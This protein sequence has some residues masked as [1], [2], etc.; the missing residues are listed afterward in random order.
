MN[1]NLLLSILD[2]ERRDIRLFFTMK[3]GIKYYTYSPGIGDNIHDEL[4]KLI[5]EYI[6]K[7]KDFEQVD[8]SPVGYK[9]GTIETC[10]CDYVASYEDVVSTFK[11][12]EVERDPISK[13][14]INK[15]NFYCIKINLDL[16][17]DKKELLLFRR[18]TKF[19]KLSTS[20]IFGS[21]SNNRFEKID[22]DLLGLDGDLDIAVYDGKMIVFNHIA[23]ERIFSLKKQYLESA[24]EAIDIIRK[25]G[26]ISNF[27]QFE[28]D[29]LNDNRITRIL[30]RM[31][32]EEDDLE[33]CFENFPNVI[34]VIDIFEL[35]IDIDNSGEED[36]IVYDNK[37]QLMDVIRLVRDS[38]YKSIIRELPGIDDAI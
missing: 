16:E 20:G 2:R 13:E 1:I 31:L 14:D 6:V 8:F 3:R 26:R 10:D 12:G 4:I 15:L 7:F 32:S 11:E 22:S 36:I 34:S 18:V 9:E 30:T 38:Y 33:K 17:E 19:R 37:E 29:C 21:I 5:K 28:E 27:D 35:E 25:A 23:L 24:Q